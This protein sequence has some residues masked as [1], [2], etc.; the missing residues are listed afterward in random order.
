[1]TA[2]V[3]VA[4]AMLSLIA[5]SAA[6]GSTQAGRPLILCPGSSNVPCCLPVAGQQLVSPCCPV[7]TI[8]CCLPAAEASG[9]CGATACT[10]TLSISVTPD[11]ATAKQK[12]TFT[13]T[14]TGGTVP[15]Q[16]VTLWQRLAG[17]VSFSQVA[18]TQTDSSGAFTFVQAVRTN[19]DWYAKTGSVVSPTLA[20]TVRASIA[21]H[22]SRARVAFGAKVTLSGSIA[23]SHAGERVKLEQRRGRRWVTIARPMLGAHSGFSVTRRMLVHSVE[24][25]RVVLAADA[26]NSRS[27]SPVVAVRR[28]R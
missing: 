20:E 16:P 2:A 3:V 10:Q 27:I 25:F 12:A 1:M 4:I 26:R 13:G 8:G 19:A 17:Q 9:C 23:P 21:L 24:R 14:L 6:A 15:A 5:S 11:P 18:Q 28:R 7:P 22:T